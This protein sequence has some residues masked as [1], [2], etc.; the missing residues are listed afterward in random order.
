M[1]LRML[2]V[3][4]LVRLVLLIS[5]VAVC[6]RVDVDDLV[7]VILD[8]KHVLKVHLLHFPEVYVHVEHFIEDGFDS[9]HAIYLFSALFIIPQE[10][11]LTPF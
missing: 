2:A 8:A 11:F 4:G 5:V 7:V 9:E 1:A 10:P 6:I 3:I